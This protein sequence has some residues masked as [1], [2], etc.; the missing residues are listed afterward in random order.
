M[1]IKYSVAT[2]DMEKIQRKHDKII[3]CGNTSHHR[4][5]CNT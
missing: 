4:R 2:L 3:R 5:Q 1:F